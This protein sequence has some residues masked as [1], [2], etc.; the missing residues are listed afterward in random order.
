[1][2]VI[3]HQRDRITFGITGNRLLRNQDGPLDQALQLFGPG[4]PKIA[5]ASAS[6]GAWITC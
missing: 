6:A 2:H 3:H 1:M 4:M 5:S